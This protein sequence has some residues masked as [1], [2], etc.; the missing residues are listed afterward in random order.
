MKIA[1]KWTHKLSTRAQ[2]SDA[3]GDVSTYMR[4]VKGGGGGP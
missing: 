4:V 2:F 3:S 1:S